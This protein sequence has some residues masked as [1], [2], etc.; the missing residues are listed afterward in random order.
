LLRD[1]Y[2]SWLYP[3]K[4][5][6]TT[7]WERWNGWTHQDGFFNPHMNSFNHYSLGSVGEWL[8]RHVAGIELD[9]ETPGFRRFVLRPFIGDGLD[10]ARA[11]YR[12]MHGEIVSDWRCCDGKMTWNVR[13]PPNTAAKVFVPSTPDSAVTE[14]GEPLERT[15]GLQVIGR[16]G[17]FLVCEAPAGSYN[18][19]SAIKL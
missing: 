9:P 1:D 6:A 2:P 18:F 10:F 3:V 8:F 16:D 12:T 7:I 13:I 19:T 5:G 4:H 17:N 14:G 11:S 15:V